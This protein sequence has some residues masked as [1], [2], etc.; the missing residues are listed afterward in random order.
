MQTQCRVS[1]QNHGRQEEQIIT[2]LTLTVTGH[3]KRR[4]KHRPASPYLINGFLKYTLITTNRDITHLIILRRLPS[5][6]IGILLNGSTIFQ[7]LSVKTMQNILTGMAG[8]IL[9]NRNMISFT[10]HMVILIL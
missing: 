8:C 9:L 6:S 5:P 2:I 4:K 3:G 10:R 1:I 7:I